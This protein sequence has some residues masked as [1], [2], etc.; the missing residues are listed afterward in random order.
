MDMGIEPY[1]ISA[2]LEGILAQRLVR[3]VCAECAETYKPSDDELEQ[4]RVAE[5]PSGPE[6]KAAMQARAKRYDK[7]VRGRGCEAC[8]GTGYR[9][10]TGIYELLPISDAIREAIAR[11]ASIS[12]LRAVAINQG[13]RPLRADGI[14]KVAQGITTLE[15]ILRVTRDEAA[16]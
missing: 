9:G 11:G 14:V 3:V 5:A 6:S 7:L 12:D 10:R 8:A 2:T 13:M 15:E 16:A 4:I 1:L